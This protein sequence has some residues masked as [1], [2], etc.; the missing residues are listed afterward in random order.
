MDSTLNSHCQL[1]MRIK[2][3]K[4][5]VANHPIARAASPHHCAPQPSVRA[6]PR[7]PCR[8]VR[9]QPPNRKPYPQVRGKK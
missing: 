6:S 1:S 8:P 3:R 5:V 9:A 7:H 2:S 4:R